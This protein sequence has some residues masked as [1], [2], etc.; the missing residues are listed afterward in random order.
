MNQSSNIPAQKLQAGGIASAISVVVLYLLGKYAG[1][2]PPPEVALAIGGLII[3]AVSFATGYVTP[4]AP[5]DSIVP[6][7]LVPTTL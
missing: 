2:N 7:P 1:F 3:G 6:K 5:R 4:P